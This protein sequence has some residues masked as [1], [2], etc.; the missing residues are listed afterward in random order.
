MNPV[1][2]IVYANDREAPA[3]FETDDWRALKGEWGSGN[4][5]RPERFEVYDSQTEL[6][7][8]L[9]PF[10]R[11]LP[12]L[13]SEIEPDKK[14]KAV[15]ANY[16]VSYAGDLHG[17]GSTLYEHD[18]P[19]MIVSWGLTTDI[20]LILLEVYRY[21]E[22]DYV[23]MANFIDAHRVIPESDSIN[24]PSHYTS[25]E[26]LEIIDL[27]E[28]MNFNRGNAVKYIARAGLKDPDKEVEDLEK[29]LWYIRREISRI[30]G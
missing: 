3:V 17:A 18:D 4:L 27:T 30:K 2:K 9:W 16:R 25:Y 28:Q 14:E 10:L 22:G 6:Y 15:G 7:T 21:S 5:F 26:G 12:D 24:H 29:A 19:R 8:P 1:Y 11:G 20:Q 23:S 13:D